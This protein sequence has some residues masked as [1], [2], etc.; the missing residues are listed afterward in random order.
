MID[1]APAD[2][3]V[4]ETVAAIAD[5]VAYQARVA[6]F[7]VRRVERLAR[8][9]LDAGK[10]FAVLAHCDRGLAYEPENPALA[11]LVGE[12]ERATAATR[13]IAHVDTEI[14]PATRRRRKLIVGGSA[15]AVI[16]AVAIAVTLR[17][18]GQ[19]ARDPWADPVPSDDLPA[20]PTVT[21]KQSGT[22]DIDTAR[23]VAGL[24]DRAASS[25]GM[26]MD[27]GDRAL[28]KGFVTVFD[29]LLDHAEPAAP[30]APSPSTPPTAEPTT[31][32][33]WL[34]LA[35]TQSTSDAVASIRRALV[36]D[37]ASADAH[38]AL[39][40]AL[41][42]TWDDTA[43]AA[44]DVAIALRDGV[45]LHAARGAARLHAGQAQAAVADLDLVIAGDRDPK[46][47]RLRARAKQALGDKAGAD[48]DLADA[49]WA[50]DTLA[51]K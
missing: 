21:V 27:P 8:E 13:D 24:F 40:A 39:C 17:G 34:E 47:R 45:M 28:V 14:A 35:G 4:A 5:P 43:I 44:C 16:A 29:K 48:R 15:V 12:A 19:P 1:W 33:G 50:G 36:I 20:Q 22:V 9:A 26:K 30:R 31:V 7:R 41:A 18:H 3:L 25:P 2:Q 10:P 49:C 11:A 51:C 32:A 37:P 46:W 42:A 6:P 23:S 38:A